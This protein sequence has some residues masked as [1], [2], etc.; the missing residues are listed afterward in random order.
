MSSPLYLRYIFMNIGSHKRQNEGSKLYDFDSWP[1]DR[2][3]LYST[4]NNKILLRKVSDEFR[5]SSSSTADRRILLIF[6]TQQYLMYGIS[7]E[8][9]QLWRR[10]HNLILDCTR[11]KMQHCPDK[12]SREIQRFIRDNAKPT[13]IIL[14]MFIWAVKSF[15]SGN[16]S[17]RVCFVSSHF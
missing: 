8:V 16:P 15:F 3:T 17:S 1:T 7:D 2:I 12:I 14:V 11:G 13:C 9:R 10:K 4:F 5:N 6:H